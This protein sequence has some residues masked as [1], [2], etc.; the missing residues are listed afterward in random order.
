MSKEKMIEILE[1]AMKPGVPSIVI[2]TKDYI[3]CL[4]ASD[5]ELTS[6]KEAS[7]TFPDCSLEEKDISAGKALM[8]LIEELTKGLPGYV[9]NLPIAKNEGEIAAAIERI[10]SS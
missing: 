9:D 6:W 4:V 3:Y 1:S 5:S 7:M 10:K 8:F 2:N